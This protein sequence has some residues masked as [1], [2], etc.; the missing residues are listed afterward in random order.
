MQGVA[1]ANLMAALLD[2][3]GQVAAVQVTAKILAVVI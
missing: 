2:L 3:A 1:V